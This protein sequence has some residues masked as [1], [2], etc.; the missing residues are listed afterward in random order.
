LENDTIG[1][2]YKCKDGDVMSS[3]SSNNSFNCAYTSE[4]EFTVSLYANDT[5]HTDWTTY[6]FQMISTVDALDLIDCYGREP[7]VSLPI[8][9]VD[10][11]DIN[12]GLL[13]TIY[14]GMLAFFGSSIAPLVALGIV[15]VIVLLMGTLGTVILK[16]FKMAS[17]GG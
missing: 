5:Q 13:P 9:L 8:P 3:F 2:A 16:V 12:K 17:E 14:F 15:I 11:K 7:C 1:Y 4:G 6:T 10:T